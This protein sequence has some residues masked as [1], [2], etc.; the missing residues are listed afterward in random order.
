MAIYL[1]NPNNKTSIK[2]LSDKFNESLYYLNKLFIGDP[3]ILHV[4]YFRIF[5][6][7]AINNFENLTPE[8]IKA[9]KYATKIVLK[10][11]TKVYEKSS[12]LIDNPKE[13]PG[14][15]TI[16]NDSINNQQT[17]QQPENDYTTKI[18]QV[19]NLIKQNLS[20]KDIRTK[21]NI[22]NNNSFKI[23]IMNPL[24]KKYGLKG[25][26]GEHLFPKL[27][28]ILLNKS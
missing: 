5:N 28:K 10:D 11:L 15:A 7:H 22:T 21:L 24:Y 12:T 14:P 26:Q 20:L 19:E 16:Q 6:N 25:K 8:N 3:S 4:E 18:L 2:Y 27:Q 9:F 1:S 23:N 17:E 13:E